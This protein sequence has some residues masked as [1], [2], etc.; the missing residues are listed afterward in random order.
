LKRVADW[1]ERYREN[2]EERIGQLDDY[3]QE[4]KSKEERNDR[5]E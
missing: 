2:W 5:K 4:L 1:V 3:L